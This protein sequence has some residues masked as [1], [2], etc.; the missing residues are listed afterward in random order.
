MVTLLLTFLLYDL[1]FPS[2][3]ALF[4]LASLCPGTHFDHFNAPPNKQI[5]SL[6]SMACSMILR[7]MFRVIK[8]A[9][10]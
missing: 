8:V 3:S 10:A 1:L 4:I 5:A 2:V 7:N 6:F 9:S